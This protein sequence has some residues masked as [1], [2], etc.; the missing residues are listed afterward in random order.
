MCRSGLL[1]AWIAAWLDGRVSYDAA[2]AAITGPDA[3][4]RVVGLPHSDSSRDDQA[5]P[6]G[7]LLGEVR[8]RRCG[9]PRL[10][11]PAPGDP[12]GLPV[13][14]EFTG[15]AL[16]AGE[17]AVCGEYGLVP[18]VTGGHGDLVT[19]CVFAVPPA[20]ADTLSPAEAS[21]DLDDAL[22]AVTAE[23]VE[24]DVPSWRTDLAGA[25]SVARRPTG[26]NLPP[27]HDQ[28]ARALLTRADQLTAVLR[29]ADADTPG[30]AVTA[31]EAQRRTQA[32]SPLRTAV[33]RARLASYNAALA[34]AT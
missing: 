21:H 24:L 19:W 5:V 34:H 25:L 26:V 28:R 27:G 31:D 10:V 32:L 15:A 8:S 3:P 30:G 1:V 20:R 14:T 29:L 13:A 2:V 17:A 4:H 18:H 22:R 9:P 23:L 11:L 6:L 12:R 7:W 16:D 33:R